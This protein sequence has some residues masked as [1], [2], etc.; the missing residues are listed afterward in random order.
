MLLLKC[1]ISDYGVEVGDKITIF[2]KDEPSVT[3]ILE[4]ITPEGIKV[5][6]GLHSRSEEVI[7]VPHETI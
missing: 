2:S 4:E 6:R 3:G 5:R 7:L 1:K